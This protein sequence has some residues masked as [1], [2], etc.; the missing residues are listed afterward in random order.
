[1]KTADKVMIN[2]QTCRKKIFVNREE[3]CKASGCPLA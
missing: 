3:I 1:M 2:H